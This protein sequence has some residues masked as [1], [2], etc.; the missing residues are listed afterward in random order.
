[1]PCLLRNSYKSLSRVRLWSEQ[2]AVHLGQHP[3]FF[4]LIPWRK[5]KDFHPANAG[6]ARNLTRRTCGE[7]TPLAGKLPVI[8]REGSLDEQKIGPADELCQ[9]PTIRLRICRIRDI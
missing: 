6:R 4:P 5:M 8:L 3:L 7:M 2:G 9:C 1:M